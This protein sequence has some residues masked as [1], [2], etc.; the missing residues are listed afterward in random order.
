[1]PIVR[2]QRIELRLWLVRG[3]RFLCLC[4]WF[5]QHSI[6]TIRS[7]DGIASRC[8]AARKTDDVAGPG[9]RF[10]HGKVCTNHLRTTAEQLVTASYVV[11]TALIGV[12]IR[13]RPYKVAL[14]DQGGD[15]GRLTIVL[16]YESGLRFT[17]APIHKQHTTLHHRMICKVGWR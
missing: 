7:V 6:A 2:C 11:V 14:L 17:R 16:F 3:R 15:L 5:D 12:V 13:A 4:T 1:M 8:V 9:R 10:T